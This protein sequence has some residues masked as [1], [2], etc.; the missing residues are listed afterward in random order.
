[1]EQRFEAYL[2]HL[3]DSLGHV[4][5]HEGLRGYC[6]G[7]MLPLARKS[8]EPLAAGIDPHA[9]RARH[10]SLHHFVAKSDW[11]DE[12][13]LERVR[14]W[15]EPALL[16]EKGTE[17]YWIV[18]DTGFP[19]K[20]KHSV[21]VARQYC[22]Q[23]GKQDNCQIAVSLTLATGKASLPVAWRLYLPEDWAADTARRTRAGVPEGVGF[24]TKPT[25]ALEQ[26]KAALTAGIARGVVLADAGYGNDTGFRDGLTE[27]GLIYAVGVQGTTTVWPEGEAPLPPK[28]WK[29]VGRK[30]RLLRRD[31]EHRP[32]SV[33]ALALGLPASAYRTVT[34]RQ[35]SNTALSGRFAAVRVRAA[36]RDQQ[37]TAMRDEE[38]LLIE[39]PEGQREP[40]KYVLSTLPADTSL[41]RLVAVTRMR[42]RI[43]RDYQELKQEFGLAHYEGRGWRGFHHHASLC[44]AAYGFIVAERLRHPDTQK[45]ATLRPPSALPQEYVPRGRSA[46]P[47]SSTQL[48]HD[49][50]L[51]DRPAAGEPSRSLSVLRTE[52]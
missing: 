33:K 35:G 34:W 2:D 11:S 45:N 46:A 6:Q 50:A 4:D 51:A 10:Q 8:V 38:W 16:R 48:D 37:R 15:V 28:P 32:V 12:R 52:K 13:L 42:W 1:M 23:L 39:W 49:L 20:G 17:C 41:E 18:D 21:G 26:L 30:P 5:R 40:E 25:I 36:H 29:G 19:K 22:G 3:C 47:A 14:A 44:I 7:L 43:E 27:L 9:V 24:Q 31:A